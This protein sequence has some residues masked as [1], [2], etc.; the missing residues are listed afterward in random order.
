MTALPRAKASRKAVIVSQS[1]HLRLMMS[2]DGFG[3][4]SVVGTVKARVA[5]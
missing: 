4:V 3:S 1:R 5:P 2:S